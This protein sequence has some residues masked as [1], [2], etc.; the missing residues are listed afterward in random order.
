MLSNLKHRTARAGRTAAL[1][2]ASLGLGISWTGAAMTAGAGVLMAAPHVQAAQNDQD[3]IIFRSGQ[4]ARGEI[5]EETPTTIRMRVKVAGIAAETS[6]NK[7]DILSITRAT[8]DG[9]EKK[10]E[11]KPDPRAAGRTPAP[12]AA[13]AAT[14]GDPNRKKVYVM[15]LSGWFGEEISQTPIRQAVRDA[16]RLEADYIIVKLNN[17]WSFNRRTEMAED[18]PEDAGA[19]D[20][21]WRA[22]DIEPIFREEIPRDWGGT[23]PKVIFWVKNAMAG[24]AF[25]PFSCRDIYF[26]SDGKMGGIGHLDKIF[27]GVGDEV[28]RQKQYSLRLTRAE[29]LAIA[30]GY[31]P[32]IVRAMAWTEYVLSVRFE[33]GRPVFI[34]GQPERDGDILLAN[35]G[36][37]DAQKDTIEALA[38]GEGKNVLTLKAD[39]ALKLGVSKGTADSV[40]DL[41]YL[42]G[43]SRN[44]EILKTQSD[45]IMKAWRD[46]I[47][48]AK[49]SLRRLARDF[50]QVQVGGDYRERTAARGRQIRIIEE[51]QNIIKR[52]EEAFDPRSI[53]VPDWNTLNILKEQIKLA[54]LADRR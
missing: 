16:K 4:E 26:F 36:R 27:D 30:G 53:G 42:L 46:G 33:G 47:D 34:E 44:H 31:D 23:P 50:E 29:G 13:A 48:N 20:Q 54:Q 22:I 5:L 49:R 32:R 15:E 12:A 9:A 17:D 7:A 14:P 10:D 45:Q 19:F 40:S 41:M 21:L 39:I 35:N 52:Y 2:V 24:A 51:M 8:R 37:D 28:A 18:I 3:V 1:L 43:I 11:S 25:L 38:R 6:Y